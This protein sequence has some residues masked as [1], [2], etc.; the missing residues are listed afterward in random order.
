MPLNV[1]MDEKAL[2]E[3]FRD[4]G[5]TTTDEK[6]V[7]QQLSQYPHPE[8]LREIKDCW[9]GYNTDNCHFSLLHYACWKGWND[10]SRELVEKYQCNPH[11]ESTWKYTPLHCACERGSIDIVTL[12]IV[13]HHC[14]P[15]CH[16]REGRT[17]LHWACKSGKLDI[18]RFLVERCHC[19]LR[20]Q[21]EDGYTPLHYACAKGSIDIVRFLIVDRQCDPAC[22]GKKGR[23]P[24]HIACE[25]GKLNIVMC[26]V[27]ECHCDPRVQDKDGYTPLHYAC[28]KGSID[29]VRFLIVDHRCDP[30]CRGWEGRTPLFYACVSGK[31]NIVKFLVEKCRCDPRV[32][33]KDGNTPLH[34]ACEVGT[35][36]IVRFLIIDR[37]CDPEYHGQWYGRTPLYF[38]CVSGKLDI[39]KFLVEECHCDP[40]SQYLDGNTPLHHACEVGTIDIVRFLI[41]DRRCDPACRGEKGRTPLHC[42]CVSGKLDI[43]K[44]LVEECHCDP[45]VQDEDGN[46]P[47]HYACEVGNIDIVRFLIIDH[48]CDPTYHGKK[49]RTPVYYACVSG[50]LDIVK[51]LV[52]ECHCDFRSQHLDGNTPLHYACEVGNIDIVR[53]LIID[54]QCDPEYH[55]RWGRTPLHCACVSGKVDIVKFLVEECYCDPRVQDMYGNTPLYFACKKGSIDLVKFLI[56]DHHCDP[57]CCDVW[58]QTPLHYACEDSQVNIVK[59]LVERCHC[60]PRAQDADGNTPLHLA[61]EG[62]SVDIVRFL[63]VDHHCDPACR[64]EKGRT[65]LHCACKCGKLDI[66]KFLVKE[67]HCDPIRG[68]DDDGKTPLHLATEGRQDDILLFL[69][70]HIP[71]L[72]VVNSV[73]KHYPVKLLQAFKQCRTEYP[74][75]SA[76][77]I[78]VLGNHGAGKTTL[79]KVIENEITTIFGPLVG[80]LRK[81]S[82]S[83][84]VPL[85][86]GII[87]V[88]IESR[89]LGQIVIYD[90]A[91]H[92]QYYSSH[93]AL[94]RSLVSSSASMFLVVVNL[95]QE[96]EEIIR[97]LHYWNSFVDNCCSS[98]GRPP[99]V[100]VFSHADEVTE[101]KPKRKSSEIVEELSHSKTSSGFSKAVTLDCRKLASRGLTKIR[102]IVAERCIKLR[103]T[104]QFDLAVQLLYAFISSK[105]ADQIAFTVSE[106]QL[107]IKQ[108]QGE[109]SFALKIGEIEI[110]PANTTELSQYLTMLS[111]KGQFLFL[112]ND[113]KVEDSWVVI[114]KMVLLAEINGTIFA[115]DNFKQHHKIANSTGVV[116][117][118]K[119][120]QVFSKQD[121]DMVVAFLQHLEFCQE[122][123]EAGVSLITSQHFRCS[124][125]PMERFFFFPALVSEEKPSGPCNAIDTPSYRCG[126]TLQ[127]SQPH[128]FFTPQFLHVLL[129]RLAFSFALAPNDTHEVQN[130]PVLKRRCFVWRNGIHWLS[131]VGVETTVEETKQNS[132]FTITMQCISGQEM[133][134]TRYHSQ[135]VKC[136]LDVK[137]ELCP[138][139]E[140]RESLVC[141]DDPTTGDTDLQHTFSIV[142]VAEAIA[143]DKP[144]IVNQPGGKM[145]RI[146]DLL[147]FEPYAYVSEECLF[148]ESN[149]NKVVSE[150]FLDGVSKTFG[151]KVHQLKQVLGIK[152]AKLQAVSA[153]AQSIQQDLPEYQVFP[154]KLN[155]TKM[156]L[157]KQVIGVNSTKFQAALARAPP[158]QRD[159]PE[160]QC[161]LVFQV[162]KESTQ[163]PTYGALRSA[164]DKYSVFCGRNPLVSCVHYVGM[165]CLCQLANIIIFILW[166]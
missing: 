74:L 86:A 46:T 102:K 119:I 14:D 142:E 126:W 8:Q 148:T 66:V 88:R 98:A 78:F 166:D 131:R 130:S 37:Q 31:L 159:Q 4:P 146:D 135:V 158:F 150:E 87:P 17:P 104:F 70:S 15:A 101:N 91:G 7:L 19:D 147:Y 72:K 82:K 132:T 75:E 105:L 114:N 59:F 79:V 121:P 157:L 24:L 128:Q 123:S 60:D 127:C 106:L 65:P 81:V 64:G 48:Q 29:I 112:R 129:L 99:T 138:T 5:S 85:T 97:Q 95:N 1:I 134:C 11:L 155:K 71:P 96:K 120:R 67:C 51:F 149:L 58:G 2:L 110:L 163:S 156:D 21:D 92:Y 165:F 68:K 108:E 49:G 118:S 80:Q 103:E 44:F 164:L 23:T 9:V 28:A 141:L 34:Y 18:V 55:G 6:Q 69:L 162:W 20:V 154:I 25:C 27:E 115:P 109:N 83:A 153:R 26:L 89:R 145:V 160:Y 137:E 100:A 57:A 124:C 117:F 152:D 33:D 36:D 35:I 13:G 39:V 144:F 84:V 116:P 111:D 76:F 73:I 42:A 151:I 94:L 113:G 54:H 32:Q 143:E 90:M 52:E 63:I 62:E 93:A 50:K 133:E 161:K 3:C 122:I 38:A 61:C 140:V 22:C 56:F 47:L 43:V 12:L 125:G 40:R 10:V 77:K 136:I 30:A 16:G 107:L 139:V 41:V 45:R 53:F